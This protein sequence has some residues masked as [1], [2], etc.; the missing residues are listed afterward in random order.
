M[1]FN[2][3]E[4]PLTF[5]T[6][7]FCSDKIS[8]HQTQWTSLLRLVLHVIKPFCSLI[9]KIFYNTCI[10]ENIWADYRS[11]ILLKESFEVHS[12]LNI[13]VQPGVPELTLVSC[14]WR[15]FQ[16]L[17]V[18]LLFPKI[19]RPKSHRSSF[20]KP[21]CHWLGCLK[22][23]PVKPNALR[24]DCTPCCLFLAHSQ[25]EYLQRKHLG[26]GDKSWRGPSS[27]AVHSWA[28]VL[29]QVCCSSLVYSHHLLRTLIENLGPFKKQSK[30]FQFY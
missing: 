26:W 16:R 5:T 1:A 15:I 6:L 3:K 18:W 17:I 27:G 25:L 13:W 28:F 29:A 10:N 8:L 24:C 12:C 23:Q 20:R 11:F 2:S 7:S 30:E 9:Q 4:E 19:Q 14:L 21:W 22:N